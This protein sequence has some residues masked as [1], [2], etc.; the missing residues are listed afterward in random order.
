MKAFYISLMVIFTPLLQAATELDLHQALITSYQ[1]LEKAQNAQGIILE[2]QC[3]DKEM[4]KTCL[5]N[6]S[7]FITILSLDAINDVSG[8]PRLD[9]VKEKAYNYVTKQ[10]QSYKGL[11][12]YYGHETLSKYIVKA[13]VDDNSV[14]LA[15]FIK[16]GIPVDQ[17][18]L[19]QM[20]EEA[21]RPQVIHR[22]N[23]KDVFRGKI[24]STWLK[25]TAFLYSDLDVVVNA[26]ALWL[27]G[28][29]GEKAENSSELKDVCR[30]VNTII[31]WSAETDDWSEFYSERNWNKIDKKNYSAWYPSPYAFIYN[32][33]RAATDGQQSCLNGSL[34]KIEKLLMA[35]NNSFATSY[36]RTLRAASLMRLIEWKQK[37]GT[38]DLSEM[39]NR[40]GE[41]VADL[42]NP[43]DPLISNRFFYY[44]V[45][46]YIG[47][48][49]YRHA[50][51]IEV[52]NRYQKIKKL[53]KPSHEKEWQNQLQSKVDLSLD[54]FR[55][56]QKADGSWTKLIKVSSVMYSCHMIFMYEYMNMTEK[57]I[58]IIQRLMKYNWT[59]QNQT[60]GFSGYPGGKDELSISIMMYVAAKIAGEDINSERM[61]LLEN[62][63]NQNGGL[64]KADFMALPYLALL[65]L[66]HRFDY[67]PVSLG[68]PLMLKMDSMLPWVKVLAYP[69]AYMIGAKKIHYM[70]E[71]KIPRRITKK[72]LEDRSGAH[73][74]FEIGKEKLYSWIEKNINDDGT[75]FDYT[76]TTVPILMALSAEGPR[77]QALIEKGIKTLESFQEEID[78]GLYQS[79][80]EASIGETYVGMNALM[81]IGIKE[82]DDMLVKAES[83]LYSMMQPTTG[84]FGFSKHNTHFPDTDDTSN[85][86]YVLKRMAMNKG[87]RSAD[88][89]FV[90]GLHWLIKNQNRD[91][92]FGTWEK[93]AIPYTQKLVNRFFP[94][95]VLSESVTEH[96]ARIVLNMALFK[97]KY[98]EVQKS[99]DKALKW[100]IKNQKEDGSYEGTWFVDYLFGTSMVLTSLATAEKSEE[101]KRA[102]EKGLAFILKHQQ[103][104]GGFSESPESFIKEES[105]PL[106]ASSPA[107]TGLIVS[108]LFMF[109]RE[110]KNIHKEYL[111]P[112]L[113]KAV[114]FVAR[115]QADDGQWH[116]LT[117]TGVTFPRTEYLIYPYIQDMGAMQAMG[118]YLKVFPE[119]NM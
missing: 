26:N 62:Y 95:I 93:E 112:F 73:E 114:K 96:T 5:K 40:A 28:L 59:N 24:F 116:D 97:D 80:G 12:K 65:G 13:D 54:Y 41:V 69:I 111:K 79:P 7:N 29:N 19:R 11:I 2:S 78:G 119:Q 21:L 34:I 25:P 1:E 100:L 4:T 83:F 3:R 109:L 33:V 92:G 104:D 47:S 63:I 105:V 113:K 107:Q 106:K 67:I 37:T 17:S 91:G 61:L 22:K 66:N 98:P 14:A 58:D 46:G 36:D 56:E 70:H 8:V 72:K 43:E 64:E 81:D 88:E 48:E 31:D 10:F 99:Y 74:S 55:N 15:S 52:F 60:G 42:L 45:W 18:L 84:A 110:E 87:E 103:Q 71:S 53:W 39:M 89:K 23:S 49:G 86:I 117:W 77:Y 115:K 102:I 27:Y 118:M 108:Q 50:L 51:R 30:Y 38:E 6:K 44:G 82:N 94:G 57:K 35:E 85:S 76:P 68:V 32:V 20:K 101:V 16:K 9:A 75:L 90:K